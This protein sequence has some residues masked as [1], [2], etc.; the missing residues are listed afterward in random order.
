MTKDKHPPPLPSGLVTFMFTDIVGSTLMKR[1]MPGELSSEREA[2]FVQRIKDPHGDIV[3]ERVKARGGFIIKSTGY[4]FLIAFADAEKAVLCAVE[5]QERLSA[6]AIFTPDGPLQI[7]IG[8][9]SG[10]AEPTE[11][12]YTASA[13]DKAARVET[14]AGNG[15]VYLSRETQ[16]AVVDKVRSISITSAGNHDMKGVGD[17]ELFLTVRAGQALPHG[18]RVPVQLK[19]D[20]P[21]S[22]TRPPTRGRATCQGEG[23]SS[24]D[25]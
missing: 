3:A 11:G 17:E 22:A 8:P 9:N 15:Q 1:K 4:G 7:R 16:A 5:I 24:C 25:G 2:A 19:P 14:K 6:A 18:T 13:V 10:H 23:Q 20:P 12:D 21:R